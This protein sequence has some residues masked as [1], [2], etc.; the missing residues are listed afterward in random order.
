MRDLIKIDPL[1]LS[2][3][4]IDI[5]GKQWMLVSAGD[6]ERF[7]TMTASWGTIGFY[8]NEPVVT[9]F[10]RPERY[11]YEFIESSD[12]FTLTVLEEGY[13]QA[14]TTLGKLSGRDCDKISQAG[15]TPQFTESGNPTFAEAKIVFECRKI[16]AQDM[17]EES[18]VEHACYEKWYGP[19]HGNLHKIY[20]GVIEACWV[21]G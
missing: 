14:L 1:S 5:I 10:I 18:F 8:S 2:E 11:T 13:R 15:L 3:N 12:R 21:K 20:M 16:F 6:R 7:N 4:V 17:T 9:I 19:G